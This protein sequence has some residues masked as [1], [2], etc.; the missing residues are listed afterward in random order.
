MSGTTCF[1]FLSPTLRPKYWGL[2]APKQNAYLQFYIAV[3]KHSISAP[4][5][6]PGT[7]Y[8]TPIIKAENRKSGNEALEAHSPETDYKPQRDDVRRRIEELQA[9]DALKYPRMKRVKFPLTCAVFTENY[10]GMKPGESKEED[11]C[12]SLRGKY[13][14]T[15]R[16]PFFKNDRKTVLFA[17]SRIEACVHGYCARWL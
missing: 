17:N 11:N 4:T 16:Q 9:A 2:S 8:R 1:R 7:V 6:D 15:P 10:A 14:D 5:R 12:I 3:R 13:L